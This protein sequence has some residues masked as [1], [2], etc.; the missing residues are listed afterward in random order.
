[1]TG[2]YQSINTSQFQLLAGKASIVTKAVKYRCI[3]STELTGNVRAPP[4]NLLRSQHPQHRSVLLRGLHRAGLRL[5]H[6]HSAG[7]RNKKPG[8][9]VIHERTCKFHRPHEFSG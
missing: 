3:L 4:S 6:F 1:M 5:V 8:A 9:E 2:N 7:R